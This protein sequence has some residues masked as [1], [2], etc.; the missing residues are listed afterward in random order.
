MGYPGCT[1]VGYPG[2][3]TR[4]E[5]IPRWCNEERG[6]TQVCTTV[7]Y[8]QVCTTVGYTQGVTRGVY[9][10]CDERC[11]PREGRGWSIPREVEGGLYPGGGY[12]VLYTIPGYLLALYPGYTFPPTAPGVVPAV[13]DSAPRCAATTLWAQS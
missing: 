2:G 12:W 3:V 9:P 1:T 7:G 11:I 13:A 10:G 6:Y 5:V 8:T 4:R